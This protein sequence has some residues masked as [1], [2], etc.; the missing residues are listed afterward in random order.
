MSLASLVNTLATRIGTEI[1]AVRAEGTKTSA[2]T[3]L[4]LAA[5]DPTADY[6]PIY[7]ASAAALKKI[8]GGSLLPQRVAKSADQ[9]NS[10]N[11]TLA[12]V[13]GMGFAVDASTEYIAEW[14][15]FVVAAAT[16]T[17]LVV[18][19]NG[20]TIGAGSIKY[21]YEAPTSGTARFQSGATAYDTALVSTGVPSVTLP[22]MH[23]VYAHFI[24]G[25]TGGT[26]AL[27]MRSEVSGS[28]ATIQR[29]SYGFLHRVG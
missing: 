29:G 22:H 18:G 21:S 27:R 23:H 19:V 10:S 28:N 8:I 3:A 15:L 1:K 17:G 2:L 5:Y 24:A 11:T 13:T 4:T 12:D 6:I 16:T 14:H 9:S 7:D 26:L 20:P 25:V